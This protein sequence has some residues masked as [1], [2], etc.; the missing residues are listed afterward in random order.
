MNSN[1]EKSHFLAQLSTESDG[2]SSTVERTSSSGWESVLANNNRPFQWNCQQYRKQMQN[3]RNYFDH[4]YPYSR[5]SY[6]ST[7]RGRG[8]IQLTGCDN[9]LGFFYSDAAQRAGKEKLSRQMKTDF[10]YIKD[11]KKTKIGQFCNKDMLEQV[12]KQ[13]QEEG[14]ILKPE[15]LINDF[16]KT[17]DTLS[18]PCNDGVGQGMTPEKFIVDSS[19][20]YWK[21]CRQKKYASSLE[22]DSDKAVATMSA[23]V[24]GAPEKYKTYNSSLCEGDHKKKDH[25]WTL[26]S[27]CSRLKAFHAF[28]SCFDES[29]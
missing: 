27:F 16:Q 23:C 4:D 18:I 26:K 14:L 19:F 24:N 22:S 7:F 1:L 12:A 29:S 6:Q 28:S 17:V 11:G 8:L 9:Y 15:E 5:N 2:F 13:L 3:D 21:R 10:Y 25:H 20:W